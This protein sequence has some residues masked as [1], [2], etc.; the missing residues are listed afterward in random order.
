MNTK[1]NT[2]GRRAHRLLSI[3]MVRLMSPMVPHGSHSL[4]EGVGLIGR[5]GIYKSVSLVLCEAE[6][7]VASL[8]S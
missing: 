2:M 5:S 7:R 1:L 6:R 4:P 8:A 3:Y